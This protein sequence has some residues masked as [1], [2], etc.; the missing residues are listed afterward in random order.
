[1]AHL[2]KQMTY[3]GATPR[4]GLDSRLTRKQPLHIWQREAG[5][6][7]QIL[8]SPV[9]FKSLASKERSCQLSSHKASPT[10]PSSRVVTTAK[11]QR[12]KKWAKFVEAQKPSG[13]KNPATFQ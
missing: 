12:G 4:H 3:V 11:H 8:E 10:H 6:A 7:W 1:M 2:I 9:H 5:M 13:I